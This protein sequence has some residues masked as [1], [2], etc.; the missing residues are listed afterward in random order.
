LT[1]AEKNISVKVKPSVLQVMRIPATWR[2]SLPAATP[3][4]LSG[5]IIQAP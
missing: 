3:L 1:L 4:L 5:V 2:A